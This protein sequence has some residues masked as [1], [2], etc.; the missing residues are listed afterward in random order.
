MNCYCRRGRRGRQAY[1]IAAGHQTRASHRCAAP[2][3]SASACQ[4]GKAQLANATHARVA[5]QAAALKLTRLGPL[6][7][8][9]GLTSRALEHW[10]FF[11]Q[12][13][14]WHPRPCTNTS[15]HVLRCRV[16]RDRQS[17]LPIRRYTLNSALSSRSSQRSNFGT[18]QGCSLSRH[19]LCMDAPTVC[20]SYV[21]RRT[22][23]LAALR[24]GS[25]HPSRSGRQY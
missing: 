6:M 11:D 19:R 1:V 16:L 15:C 17:P 8:A 13:S 25:S 14:P 4:I 18:L 7:A 3:K 12:P 23:A 10:A 5:N 21:G 9:R 22:D 2:S 20:R 24:Y